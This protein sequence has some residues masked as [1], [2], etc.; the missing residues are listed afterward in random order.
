MLAAGI[1]Q[2]Q[3]QGGEKIQVE[4]RNQALSDKYLR[5]KD[6]LDSLLR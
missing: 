1:K 2:V 3:Q 6:W 4:S 5:W